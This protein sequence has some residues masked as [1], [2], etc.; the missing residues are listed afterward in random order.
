MSNT[1]S[2]YLATGHLRLVVRAHGQPL[3]VVHVRDAVTRS[4]GTAADLMRPVRTL[5]ADT[6]MYAALSTMR[7]SRNHLA[8]V[9]DDGGL[10]GLV[11][12]QDLLD[13]LLLPQTP[14]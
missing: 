8:L 1:S 3:G 12:L 14:G 6:P 5:S 9:E 7:E 10:A 13:R 2:T 4:D 11:T